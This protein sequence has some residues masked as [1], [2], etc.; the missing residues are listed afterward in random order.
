MDEAKPKKQHHASKSGVKAKKKR[1]KKEGPVERHNAKAFTFSGGKASIA[2]KVQHTMDKKAK[3]E[4][5]DVI[6]KT[7]EVPAP[8]VVVV[9]GPPGVGKT[10]LIRSL[11]K[12]YTRQNLTTVD[13]P[14]TMVSSKSRRLTFFETNNDVRVMLDL[15]KIADLVLVLVDASFGFEMETFEFLNIMQVHGFP[16]VLGVLT[17]LDKFR[18]NKSLRRVKKTMKQRFWTEIYEGAK[19]FYLS[20]LQYGRYN[21][22]EIANLTRFITVQ[23]FQPLSWRSAHPYMLSHRWEDMTP[24]SFSAEA[25]RLVNFY[26]Y[27]SGARLR[28]GMDVHIPGV[29]DFPIKAITEYD[30]P[31]PPPQAQENER[32]KFHEHS[33][34]G[35]QKNAALRTLADRHKILYAPACNVGNVMLD[36]DA[37]YINVPEYK[38]SFTKKEDLIKDPKQVNSSD[39]EQEESDEEQLNESVT[40]V[41]ELQGA[42]NAL[43][44][45]LEASELNLIGNTKLDT[46]TR[47]RAPVG[48]LPAIQAGVEATEDQDEDLHFADGLSGASSDEG[49]GDDEQDSKIEEV[50]EDEDEEDEDEEEEEGDAEEGGYS[51]QSGVDDKL[52][53]RAEERFKQG[54]SL[55]DL[56]YKC[57]TVQK[58]D[59]V[60][61]AK[62][63]QINLFDDDEESEE[64]EA[65]FDENAPHGEV[66]A[67]A[68]NMTESSKVQLLTSVDTSNLFSFEGGHLRVP[69]RDATREHWDEEAI[70]ALKSKWFITGGWDSA[71]EG[72]DEDPENTEEKTEED[73]EK[74]AEEGVAATKSMKTDIPTMDGSFAIGSYVRVTIEGIPA[75]CASEFCPKRPLVLGGLLPGETREGFVQL[76]MKKHRWAPKILK[77]QDVMLVST[78]W[79]RFQTMPIYAIEDRNKRIRMLKYTPEHMHCTVNMYA[80]AT[81]PST[82]VLF[83]RNWDSIE[84]FR[85]SATGLVLESAPSFRMVKKLKLVGYPYKIFKNTTFVKDMFSSD[86][87]ANKCLRSKLQTVSGIR[88]EIK[89]A[90]G[91]K[92]NF[93][94]TFEDKLVNS[95]II[96]LKAW[97]QVDPKPFYNPMIDVPNWRRMKTIASLR[98][99]HLV[100]IP[101][102][103]D[104]QYGKKPERVNKDFG[105]LT[106]PTALRNELPFMSKTVLKEKTKKP[107][108]AKHTA[109]IK[110]TQEKAANSLLQKLHLL[111]KAKLEKKIQKSRENLVKKKK[112]QEFIELRRGMVTK[113][114]RR[115]RHAKSGREEED[116]RKKMKFS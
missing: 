85:I 65:V 19:L 28:V 54:P 70:E 51:L 104:S 80:P 98:R 29:G 71:D 103:K 47:R 60:T 3:R 46:R 68:A 88:G 1:D 73:A 95:D 20:G 90:I 26:G 69:T 52:L 72:E 32:R 111:Q 84:S 9:H 86:L 106:I 96:M 109:V 17:H 91:Q 25:N 44:K 56:V 42:K 5:M 15:A 49:E 58:E 112:R 79:R 34:E 22:V 12:H 92:G 78:G 18:D 43:G 2:R 36:A 50:E 81:P 6:D 7:P 21:K 93:R 102:K 62:D 59:A 63:G 99:E 4:K 45:S 40:M 23:K 74:E 82:G 57:R 27:L 94:A 67:D 48:G 66:D 8:L 76:R 116:R 11:V 83:I 53:A 31:C 37:M 55:E 64:E 108:F 113:E 107:K 13:G 14:V 10:T 89:K 33:A 24:E 114:K 75:E 97:I 41:R 61:K 39:S 77:S 115:V 100:P 101:D 16:R 35:R 38:V 110:S 105:P 30:D 87:E